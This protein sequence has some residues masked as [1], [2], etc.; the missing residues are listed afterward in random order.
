MA[1]RSLV[2]GRVSPVR[3]G[4]EAECRLTGL[5][6][7][8]FES[9]TGVA[10]DRAGNVYVAD[11]SNNRVQ[12]FSSTG[13]FIRQWGSMGDG[14]LRGSSDVALDPQGNLYVVDMRNRRVQKFSST[15]AFLGKLG[16]PKKSPRGE[17][18]FESPGPIAVDREGRVYVGDLGDE[19]QIFVGCSVQ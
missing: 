14:L 11:T 6:R 9:P 13:N 10:V 3:L 18:S 16:S 2:R 1:N 12:K 4:I 5:R 15:G 19:I 8:Q 17:G 7:C